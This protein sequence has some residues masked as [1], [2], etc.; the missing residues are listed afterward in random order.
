MCP[1]AAV[2]VT[3]HGEKAGG[4]GDLAPDVA[5]GVMVFRVGLG[6][7]VA[8]GS[9]VIMV[10]PYETCACVGYDASHGRRAVA[11]EFLSAGVPRVLWN[12]KS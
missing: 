6:P 9:H 7:C 12:V 5:C 4:C 3:G 2:G 10:L 8:C 1:H 11:V